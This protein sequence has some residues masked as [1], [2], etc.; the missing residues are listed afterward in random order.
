[1]KSNIGWLRGVH[2]DDSGK[3]SPMFAETVRLI[4]TKGSKSKVLK[5]LVE[6]VQRRGNPTIILRKDSQ[7]TSFPAVVA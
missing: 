7:K 1:M 2:R 3:V 4:Q 5:N 6:T